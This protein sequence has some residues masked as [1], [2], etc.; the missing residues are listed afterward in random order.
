[1]GFGEQVHIPAF[2]SEGLEV[3]AVCARRA[4]RAREAAERFGIPR[5]FTNHEEMLQMDGLDAVSVAS[6]ASLHYP[7]AM[8]ALEAGKH[9]LCEKPFST[10]Q[11]R[12]R[13]LWQKAKGT[14]VTAMIAHEFRFASARMR[15]KELIDEGYLGPLH[16]ALMRLAIGPRRGFR[17]RPLTDWDDAG[18]GN[19]F[20]WALGSHYIDCLR[21]WFGEISSVWGQVF[22]HFGDRTDPASGD[23]VQATSDDTFHFVVRFTGGGWATMTGTSA[24]PFGPGAQIEI[25]G[26][27]GTLVTP[28]V[29]IGVNPPAHGA[30][31]GA[32]PGDEGLAEIPIPERLQPFADDRDDRLVPFRLL[33]REFLRGIREGC[34]PAPNFYDGFRCLQVLDA[35]REASAAGRVVHIQPEE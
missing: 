5:V 28:H 6:P 22:T 26:R 20:L 4:A 14:G 25:Y 10:E 29:G 19:G 13:E 11:G 15:A 9:V 27:E 32:K 30:L 21:H 1:V 7:M 2:Q 8:A 23:A 12:A 17:P 31:L 16:M 35:V 34:S 33:V 3:V 18:Q 24:A